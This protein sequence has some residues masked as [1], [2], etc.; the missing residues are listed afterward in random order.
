VTERTDVVAAAASTPAAATAQRVEKVLD[1]QAVRHNVAVLRTAAAGRRLMPVIKGNGY[2]L[3]AVAVAGLLI[4]AGVPAL[5]VDTVAEGLEL[6]A[7]GVRAPILVMDVDVAANARS[8]ADHDLMAAVATVEQVRRHADEA[9]R[10]GAPSTIWL[11]AN[12]G[13]NRFGPRD[14]PGFDEVLAQLHAARDVLRVAGIFAHLSSSAGDPDETATQAAQFQARAAR[15]RALFGAGCSVSLAATHGLLHPQALAGSDWVRPGIGLYGLLAPQ[16]RTLPGWAGSP[17]AGLRPAI[18]VRARILDI[19]DL[20]EAEGVGYD[21]RAA[22]AGRRLAAVGIGFARGLAG[23]PDGLAGFLKGQRCP[24]VG[25]PGMDCTQF[26]VTGAPAARPGD[27][28]TFASN[29]APGSPASMES[30]ARQL[31]RSLYELLATLRMPVRL[32]HP[33]GGSGELATDAAD[34]DV[35]SMTDHRSGANTHAG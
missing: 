9:D 26:D 25:R 7:A 4:E 13:F 20:P 2:G 24:M 28:L 12:V 30:L 23:A 19:L 31:D 17:L 29:S 5:A 18:S 16:S 15:V 3:G 35:D 32:D 11:R 33:D 21:R 8:C 1:V 27:W 10:R 6:R 34:P 14:E 22:P